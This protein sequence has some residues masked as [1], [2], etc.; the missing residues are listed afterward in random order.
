MNNISIAFVSV[1]GAHLSNKL[2]ILEG[3]EKISSN[4]LIDP[5]LA[6]LIIS[7]LFA[8][9]LEYSLNL[10]VVPSHCYIISTILV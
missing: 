2:D 1:S 4:N 10:V 7:L 6:A 8:L 9:I 5:I 3:C